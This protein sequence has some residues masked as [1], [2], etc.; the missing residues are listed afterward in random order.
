[1]TIQTNTSDRRTLVYAISE[2]LHT[3]PRYLRAPTYAY[4]VG[5]YT[6]DRYGSITGDDFA[7]LREFLVQNGYVSE[8]AFSDSGASAEIKQPV[9][10]DTQTITIPV[11]NVDVQQLRNLTFILYSRQHILN[12]MTGGD[13]I[14]IPSGLIDELKTSMP[15]TIEA[16]TALLEDYKARGM[17]GFDFKSGEFTLTFPYYEEEPMRWTTFAGLQGRILQSALAAV[18]VRPELIQ[19]D[20]EAE[21]YTAYMWLQRLGYKGPEMR[22]QRNILIK[23]LHGYAA[24]S[25]GEKMQKHSLKLKALRDENKA[26]KLKNTPE[27][28]DTKEDKSHD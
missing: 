7:P 28:V 21:K 2:E 18:W 27:G 11:P 3:E 25:N 5:D 10:V 13:T 1:M 17:A 6:V 20:E 19:P 26:S 23:H 24:F 16:F 15:E 14:R 9:H 22:E 12:L 4:Q 8:D